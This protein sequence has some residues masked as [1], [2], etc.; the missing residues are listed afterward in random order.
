MEAVE[1]AKLAGSIP[2]GSTGG[3][4]AST[5]QRVAEELALRGREEAELIV[6]QQR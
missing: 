1:A 5:R 2:P 4:S 6:Q 3:V